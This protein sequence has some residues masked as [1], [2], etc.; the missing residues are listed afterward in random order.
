MKGR[1]KRNATRLGSIWTEK[2]TNERKRVKNKT[3]TLRLNLFACEFKLLFSLVLSAAGP[4]IIAT[5]L[6]SVSIV[7]EMV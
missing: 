6:E 4:S 3:V 1:R 2:K 7:V 5:D